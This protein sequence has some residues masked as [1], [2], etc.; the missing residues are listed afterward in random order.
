[1][2]HDAK[3]EISCDNCGNSIFYEMPHGHD[4]QSFNDGRYIAYYDDV[5]D[6]IF[7]KGWTITENEEHYCCF[8]CDERDKNNG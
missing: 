4:H 2:I 7:S 6:F 8:I 3:I 1:M 5:N